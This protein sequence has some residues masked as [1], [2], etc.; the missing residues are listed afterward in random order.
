[1]QVEDKISGAWV[2]VVKRKRMPTEFLLVN[3]K[4][5]ALIRP[6]SRWE[7]NIKMDLK[8]TEWECVWTLFVVQERD[9]WCD[10]VNLALKKLHKTGGLT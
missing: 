8:R 3:I 2:C 7:N 1:M 6:L 9:G 5:K 10:V 4:E